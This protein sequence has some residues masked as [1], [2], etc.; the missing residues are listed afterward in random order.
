MKKNKPYHINRE[1]YKKCKEGDIIKKVGQVLLICFSLILITGC[2]KENNSNDSNPKKEIYV[3]NYTFETRTSEVLVLDEDLNFLNKLKP[4]GGM[5]LDS[6]DTEGAIYSYG[7]DRTI[8]KINVKNKKVEN[9]NLNEGIIKKI[10]RINNSTWAVD[11]G[12][13]YGDNMYKFNIMNLDTNEKYDYDGLPMYCSHK[14][15]YIYIVIYTIDKPSVELLAFNTDNGLHERVK[16]KDID[17]L[18]NSTSFKVLALENYI[19]LIDEENFDLYKLS[20]HSLDNVENA[21]NLSDYNIPIASRDNMLI[22]IYQFDVRLDEENL[23][24]GIND[25]NSAKLLKINTIDNKIEEILRGEGNNFAYV[26]KPVVDGDYI[27][28]S[29]IKAGDVSTIS[30]YNWKTGELIKKATLGDYFDKKSQIGN[31][32]M[33]NGE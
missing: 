17:N 24:I 8:A 26:S 33:Y 2:V 31:L 7:S 19:L 11:G 9:I 1:K 21:G 32:T 5:Y 18:I 6:D 10:E 14:D 27:Y 12:Y 3:S 30:K 13:F 23:L 22:Q 20:Y 4:K 29:F 28:I 25:G 15:N 16:V